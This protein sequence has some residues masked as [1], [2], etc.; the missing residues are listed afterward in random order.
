MRKPDLPGV[1]EKLFR[2]YESLHRGD[3]CIG[4]IPEALEESGLAHETLVIFHSDHGGAIRGEGMLHHHGLWA[5]V[6]VRWPGRVPPVRVLRSECGFFS[7]RA[8]GATH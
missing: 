2:Y 8:R 3:A 7:A 6:I 4:G 5:P 1:R